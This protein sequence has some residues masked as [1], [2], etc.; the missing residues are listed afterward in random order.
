VSTVTVSRVNNEPDLVVLSTRER[1]HA[2]MHKL[3]YVPN[4][5]ARTMRTNATHTIGFLV[6]DLT[7]YPNAAVAQAAARR[8]AEAGYALLLASSDQRP[9]RE[10][11]ALSILRTR[12]VDGM[13]LY[14]C[15][16]EHPSLM[17]AVRD[18][19]VPCVLLDRDIPSR[20][21][22]IYSDHRDVMREA[23]RQLAGLG[24]RR[25]T[26]L[27]YDMRIRPSLE[28][29]SAFSEAMEQ[30]GIPA[31]DR[32]VLRLP[33]DVSTLPV[34]QQ[35]LFAS[36]RS[37]TAAIVEGS[38]LLLATIQ[39]ARERGITLPQDLS[40]IGIDADDVATAATPEISCVLRDFE[41]IGMAAAEAML[42]R[43]QDRDAPR[44]VTHLPSRLSSRFS[45]GPPSAP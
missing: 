38:R 32:L 36:K 16:Q 11:E 42:A 31:A 8:L 29:R 35:F 7:I 43:L 6:P 22:R 27:Q 19:D 18:L 10:I 39:A 37:P 44:V 17:S 1:V 24:H 28:R 5:A 3:G 26:L 4:L 34:L 9:E 15:D 20:A 33:G 30:A 40:I 23:V 12:Q 25:I 14:V 21:D 13:M 2:A 41:A 45:V